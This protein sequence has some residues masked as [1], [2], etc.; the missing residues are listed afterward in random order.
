VTGSSSPTAAGAR[1]RD[2][3]PTRARPDIEVLVAG[4]ADRPRRI[5]GCATPGSRASSSARPALR[6][7]RLHRSPGGRRMTDDRPA[8]PSRPIPH[9]RPVRELGVRPDDPGRGREAAAAMDR[10]VM[11]APRG[12]AVGPRRPEAAQR[13]A[14]L[15]LNPDRRAAVRHRGRARAA[16]ASTAASGTVG[17]APRRA[18]GPALWLTRP[19]TWVGIAV[20]AVVAGSHL[21]RSHPP[22]IDRDRSSVCRRLGSGSAGASVRPAS[23]QPP[24]RPFTAAPRRSAAGRSRQAGARHDS[25][26]SRRHAES[27]VDNDLSPIAAGNFVACLVRVLHRRRLPP[28]RDAPGPRARRS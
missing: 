15:L 25:N 2:P 11:A 12:S 14:A 6:G 7:D 4:G 10:R 8:R 13:R 16:G 27:P 26:R 1:P 17:A 28:R 21:R 5:A 3:R 22:G 9:V 19:L 24:P 18:P 20:V 23:A